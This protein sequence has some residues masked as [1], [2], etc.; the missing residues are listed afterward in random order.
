[1]GDGES[2]WNGQVHSF[3]TAAEAMRRILIENARR[4]RRVKHGGYLRRVELDGLDMAHTASGITRKQVA[5]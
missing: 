3:G 5:N 1:M 2:N 4:K